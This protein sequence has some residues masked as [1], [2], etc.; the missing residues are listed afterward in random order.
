[1]NN[2]NVKKIK[3]NKAIE[4]EVMF[5]EYCKE[6]NVEYIKL[7]NYNKRDEFLINPNGKSPDFYCK[8]NGKEI[9]VEVK[10]LTNLTN[11]KREKI[12]MEDAKQTHDKGSLVGPMRMFNP[13]EE[14]QGPME[15]FLKSSSSKFKNL[16]FDYPK[17]LLL[18]GFFGNIDFAI[19]SIFLGAYDSF[20]KKNGKLEFVGKRK[21]KRALFDKTGSNVSAVIY[22]NKEENRYNGVGNPNAKIFFPEEFFNIFFDNIN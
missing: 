18:N 10:M 6:H 13:D 11:A 3:Q 12:M 7:D 1:M 19:H 17:I 16:K 8:K 22:W 4:A 15:T 20:S 9:F 2:R 14:L 21:I 5:E